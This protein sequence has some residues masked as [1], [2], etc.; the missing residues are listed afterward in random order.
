MRLLRKKRLVR[1]SATYLR[2]IFCRHEDKFLGWQK[3]KAKS[4]GPPGP[5][6]KLT[7][8]LLLSG[9]FSQCGSHCVAGC[10]GSHYVKH[11]LQSIE[12]LLPLPPK[13]RVVVGGWGIKGV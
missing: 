8:H 5:G 10:P 6:P 3:G 11:G 1:A 12:I 9:L 13:C 2:N 4:R 7:L